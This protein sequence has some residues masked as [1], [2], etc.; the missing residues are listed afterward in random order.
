MLAFKR[1]SFFSGDNNNN[2][3]NFSKPKPD[4][5]VLDISNKHIKNKHVDNEDNLKIDFTAKKNIECPPPPPNS[6]D[7]TFH[8]D[9]DSYFKQEFSDTPIL[10]S[11]DS[12]YY[13]P[14]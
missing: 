3:N 14:Q 12:V 7:R 1:I 4:S 9:G 8:H 6:P 5:V 2:N 13:R 10:I 11:D